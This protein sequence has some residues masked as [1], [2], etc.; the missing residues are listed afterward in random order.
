MGKLDGPTDC[1][2]IRQNQSTLQV[3][4]K[5]IAAGGD[6]QASGV[7]DEGEG[8]RAASPGKLNVN[9]GPFADI[10]IFSILLDFNRLLFFS[11]FRGVFSLLY[12]KK[13]LNKTGDSSI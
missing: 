1:K 3:T 10:L 8:E 7:T 9:T 12:L 11:V 2:R 4:G 13:T 6:V 5:S